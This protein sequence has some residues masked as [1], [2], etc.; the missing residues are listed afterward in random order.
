MFILTLFTLET[1]YASL[2]QLSFCIL[3]IKHIIHLEI[4]NATVKILNKQSPIL[5][6]SIFLSILMNYQ[7]G[8]SMSDR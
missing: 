6:S 4:E 3:H 8:L 5:S 1:D 2:N 7:N